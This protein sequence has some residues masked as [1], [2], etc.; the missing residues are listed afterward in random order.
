MVEISHMSWLWSLWAFHGVC[1]G[2]VY[3]CIVSVYVFVY[4]ESRVKCLWL[5]VLQCDG[6]LAGVQ[7]QQQQPQQHRATGCEL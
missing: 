3:E 1:V 6:S 2:T 5:S 7:Q 4:N